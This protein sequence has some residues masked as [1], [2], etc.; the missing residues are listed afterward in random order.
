ME[1]PK[2]VNW[3]T[4]KFRCSSL[5]NIMP[6]P[7]AKPGQLQQ[8]QKSELSKIYLKEVWGFE[9]QIST[10]Q[11]E[12]GE[13]CE[14]EGIDIVC[15]EVYPD[16]VY[17]KNAKQ[18]ENEFIKG[19]PDLIAIKH[20]RVHDIKSSWDLDTFHRAEVTKS[21]QCQIRA[22]AWLLGYQL[23][24]VD[25]V[26]MSAPEHIFD[27]EVNWLEKRY[28]D[29]GKDYSDEGFQKEYESL[30]LAMNYD[31]IPVKKRLKRFEVSYDSDFADKV[32]DN[33]F[34]LRQELKNMSL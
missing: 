34:L 9:K 14:P 32:R 27:R 29:M 15:K 7:R 11:M 25:K 18:Y 12:K 21:N 28:D 30:K 33:V 5:G 19:T 20:N 10:K 17:L 8:T 3:N 13:Y 2:K 26:L 31:H 23:M 22:Y 4:Y 16:L 6:G 1:Y 24:E